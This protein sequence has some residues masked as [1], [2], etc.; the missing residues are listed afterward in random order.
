VVPLVKIV[1]RE[2][3]GGLVGRDEVIVVLKVAAEKD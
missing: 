1:K 2:H 3:V